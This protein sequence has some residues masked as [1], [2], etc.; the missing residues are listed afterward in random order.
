MPYLPKSSKTF[1][2]TTDAKYQIEEM[3][4]AEGGKGSFV[5]F[6]LENG[7]KNC[8]N[9]K[10]HEENVMELQIHADGMPVSKSGTV[11]KSTL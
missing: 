7:L 1:L 9:K 5:Y 4:D 10:L 2:R 6:S 11:R 8:V 3:E